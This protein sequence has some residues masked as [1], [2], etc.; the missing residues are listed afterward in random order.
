MYFT[1]PRQ[2]KILQSPKYCML[3]HPFDFSQGGSIQ[4]LLCWSLVH[5][6]GIRYMNSPDTIQFSPVAFHSQLKLC[7]MIRQQISSCSSFI[8]TLLILRWE[9]FI[10]R[11]K[12]CPQIPG[13]LGKLVRREGAVGW[14]LIPVLWW[15]PGPAERAC[16]TPVMLS[17]ILATLRLTGYQG[18]HIS[19]LTR[20][21]S[22]SQGLA[23]VSQQRSFSLRCYF[24][25]E[26]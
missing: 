6:L 11:G 21:G 26:V 23:L 12:K 20:A 18:N 7:K 24:Y 13:V 25:P 5:S 2:E 1:L 22:Q 15:G 9:V 10:T 19:G 3:R 14:F 8:F 17:P 4:Q 16:C